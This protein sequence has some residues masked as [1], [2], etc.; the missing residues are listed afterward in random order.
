MLEHGDPCN[1]IDMS[2]PTFYPFDLGKE[3][4]VG[5][6]TSEEGH[7]CIGETEQIFKRVFYER[8]D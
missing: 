1:T 3:V 7:K 8:R 4:C 6:E 5:Y 2:F